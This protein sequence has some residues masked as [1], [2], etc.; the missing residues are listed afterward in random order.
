MSD[1]VRAEGWHNWGK[2]FA[3]KVARYSEF[4]ST[5]PGSKE[6]ARVKWTKLIGQDEALALTPQKVLGG[7]DGW[8]PTT[9]KPH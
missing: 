6:G 3:E 1:V 2:P 5:G 4:G 8:D 7:A 9:Q